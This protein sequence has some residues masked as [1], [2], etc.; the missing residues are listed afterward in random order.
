MR[1]SLT[2]PTFSCNRRSRWSRPWRRRKAP[3]P[4]EFDGSGCPICRPTAVHRSVIG[5][6]GPGRFCGRC[7]SLLRRRPRSAGAWDRLRVARGGPWPPA[8]GTAHRGPGTAGGMGRRAAQR[9]CRITADPGIRQPGRASPAGC[10]TLIRAAGTLPGCADLKL[11]RI[12]SDGRMP[13]A[14]YAAAFD[15][16]STR[17][18]VG[19]LVAGDWHE[20][21]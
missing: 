20:R 19:L 7:L 3:P 2:R 17:P 21:S 14:V 10:R 11:P 16:A 9:P 13:M 8:V 12:A 6:A 18:R 15:P 5:L 4:T 1:P